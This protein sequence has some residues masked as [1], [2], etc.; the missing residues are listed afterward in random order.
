MRPKTATKVE[1]LLEANAV[2]LEALLDEA[3]A[4][5]FPASDP[6]AVWFDDAPAPFDEARDS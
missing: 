1:L 3:L 2:H 5:S 4:D 6:I